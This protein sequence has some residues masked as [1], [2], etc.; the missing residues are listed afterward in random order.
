ML[1]RRPAAWWRRPSSSMASCGWPAARFVA[2]GGVHGGFGGS[3]G[4]VLFAYCCCS[5]VRHA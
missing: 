4:P 2:V 1:Q 5:G 3:N